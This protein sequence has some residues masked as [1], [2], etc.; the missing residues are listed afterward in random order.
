MLFGRFGLSMMSPEK[1]ADQGLMGRFRQLRTVARLRGEVLLE[2]T[3]ML[4]IL[5]PRS[6]SARSHWPTAI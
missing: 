2:T 6:R 5:L 1:C 4:A 3:T